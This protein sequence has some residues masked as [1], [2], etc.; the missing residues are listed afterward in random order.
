MV[1]SFH[2]WM[3]LNVRM[4]DAYAAASMALNALIACGF[5]VAPSKSSA[6]GH[7]LI[8]HPG[9]AFWRTHFVRSA[10]GTAAVARTAGESDR[11]EKDEA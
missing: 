9:G 10:R 7:G 11:C 3:V 4:F 8:G 1:M 6:T 2:V 5:V